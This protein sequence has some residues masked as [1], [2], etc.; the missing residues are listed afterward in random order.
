MTL[1]ESGF[2]EEVGVDGVFDVHHV[3]AV[4]AVADDAQPAGAGAGEHAGDEVRIADAPDQVRAQ[5][6]G[7]QRGELAASTSRSAMALVSGYGLGQSVV[8]GSDSSAP[9]SG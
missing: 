4:A 8:S 9:A 3:D 2:G 5:R 7:A 1:A 6:D